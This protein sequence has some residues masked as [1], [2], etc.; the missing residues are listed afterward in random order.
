MIVF[1][2]RERERETEYIG[3]SFKIGLEVKVTTSV[4]GRFRCS[5]AAYLYL[6]PLIAFLLLLLQHHHH[7]HQHIH[8]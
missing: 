5:P 2:E 6:Q 4:L 1:A 8:P 7:H 3:E